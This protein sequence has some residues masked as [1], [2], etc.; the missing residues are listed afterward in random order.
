MAEV[1]HP[2]LAPGLHVDASWEEV[3]VHGGGL[4]AD[5]GVELRFGLTLEST[6]AHGPSRDPEL[7]TQP[8]L[9]LQEPPRTVGTRLRSGRLC[10][11]RLQGRDT[12]RVDYAAAWPSSGS[13]GL[14]NPNRLD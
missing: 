12:K 6:P 11:D 10:L 4:R 8:Q 5:H 14:A 3:T 7:G 13:F 1:R 9:P 2:A